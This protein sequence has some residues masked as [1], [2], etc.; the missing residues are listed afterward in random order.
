MCICVKWRERERVGEKSKYLLERRTVGHSWACSFINICMYC[1][2]LLF[3]QIPSHRKPQSSSSCQMVMVSHWLMLSLSLVF[4]THLRA[5]QHKRT[6]HLELV[7][8]VSV[9]Q[10]GVESW[11]AG[12]PAPALC[13]AL[14][15]GSVWTHFLPGALNEPDVTS[16]RQRLA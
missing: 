2:L 4:V 8:E 9:G 5:Y 11:S 3:A 14:F 1:I 10:A 7:M 12:K 13:A 6:S 16:V 15:T